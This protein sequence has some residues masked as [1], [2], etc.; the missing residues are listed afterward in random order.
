MVDTD[1]DDTEKSRWLRDSTYHHGD[2]ALSLLSSTVVIKGLKVTVIVPAKEVA[3][4]I[5]GVYLISLTYKILCL[6]GTLQRDCLGAYIISWLSSYIY[7]SLFCSSRDYLTVQNP[8]QGFANRRLRQGVL[9]QTIK[10]LVEAGIVTKV[11]AIDAESRDGTGAVAAACGANVLQ[12]AEIAPELGTSKGKGDAMWRALLA[13]SPGSSAD[14][15]VAFL[16]GDTGDPTPAHLIGIIGPLIMNNGIQ[17]VRGMFERPFQGSNGDVR[18]HGMFLISGAHAYI[19][20]RYAI[21][22]VEPG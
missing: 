22:N 21:G 16:D 9:N 10:P 2:F 20:S 6:P 18:P 3:T 5:G 13:T 14:E 19:W 17:M 1:K 4:T 15:I 11:Y 7:L 8:T 12:C